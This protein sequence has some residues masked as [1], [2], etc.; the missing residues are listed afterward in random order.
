MGIR[1]SW[2]GYL[3]KSTIGIETDSN[4]RK[5]SLNMMTSTFMEKTLLTSFPPRMRRV[6]MRVL[7]SRV[8]SSTWMRCLPTTCIHWKEKTQRNSQLILF[9]NR[10]RDRGGICW[11]QLKSLMRYSLDLLIRSLRM[12]FRLRHQDHLL[13]SSRAN[14]RPSTVAKARRTLKSLNE[15]NQPQLQQRLQQLQL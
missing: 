14:A 4:N 6:A 8:R 15:Y 13:L 7:T 12:L 10:L 3:T 9:I 1:D 11:L 2:I 5:A